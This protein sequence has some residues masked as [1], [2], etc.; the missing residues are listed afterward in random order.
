MITNV[1]C[2]GSNFVFHFFSFLALVRLFFKEA[3]LIDHYVFLLNAGIAIEIH[4]IVAFDL[5]LT[6]T[7]S[8]F[9]LAMHLCGM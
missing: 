7:F 3:S 6:S 9:E 1:H 4:A 8:S 5:F 2:Q